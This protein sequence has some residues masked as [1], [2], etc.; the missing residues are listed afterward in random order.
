[1]Y[2]HANGMMHFCALYD[3]V[4]DALWGN[5]LG[6]FTFDSSEG[7]IHKKNKEINWKCTDAI[8]LYKGQREVVCFPFIAETQ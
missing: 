2:F 3:A 8:L 6:E 5:K 1:M 7:F 4:S